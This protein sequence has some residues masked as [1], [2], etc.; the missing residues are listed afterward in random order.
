[1]RKIVLFAGV[2]LLSALLVSA[3]AVDRKLSD[4]LGHGAFDYHVVD[5]ALDSVYATKQKV[6]ACIDTM[7]TI[8]KRP[9]H[10][11]LDWASTARDTTYHYVMTVPV[12][13]TA[14]IRAAGITAHIPPVGAVGNDSI[15][16][17]M[18]FYDASKPGM[19]KYATTQRLSDS[20]Q[21]TTLPGVLVADSTEVLTIDSVTT[22]AAGDVLYIATYADTALGGPENGCG[23]TF[24]VDLTE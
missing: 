6:A 9:V 1:M 21:V 19:C 17:Y 16:M 13:M 10:V 2:L 20:S 8:A 14:T 22:F 4:Y 7:S 11:D 5:G 12:G 23:V 15:L 3:S 24:D 18:Y